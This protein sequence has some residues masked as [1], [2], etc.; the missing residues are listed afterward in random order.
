MSGVMKIHSNSPI[1][2]MDLTLVYVVGAMSHQILYNIISVCIK[3]TKNNLLKGSCPILGCQTI[4]ICPVS[5]KSLC[6]VFKTNT[7]N[8]IN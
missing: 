8:L 1:T 2:F 6:I 5:V 7:S 3:K 4:V